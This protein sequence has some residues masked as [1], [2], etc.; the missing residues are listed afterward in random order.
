VDPPEPPDDWFCPVLPG[1]WFCPEPPDGLFG[2]VGA[3]S[4]PGAHPPPFVW[5]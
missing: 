1:D 4:Q 5:P 2:C 3:Q